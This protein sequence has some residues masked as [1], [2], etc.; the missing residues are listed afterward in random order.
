MAFIT[1]SDHL[2]ITEPSEKI[3]EGFLILA[4]SG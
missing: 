4:I 2:I 1:V 3:V